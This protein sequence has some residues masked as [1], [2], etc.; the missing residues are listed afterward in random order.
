MKQYVESLLLSD[1]CIPTKSKNHKFVKLNPGC[2][3]TLIVNNVK[4]KRRI[5]LLKMPKIY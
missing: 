2:F 1:I 4:Q 3:Y 5:C